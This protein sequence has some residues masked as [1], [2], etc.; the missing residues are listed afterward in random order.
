MRITS[1]RTGFSA[2]SA[3]SPAPRGPATPRTRPAAS[4]DTASAGRLKRP[5][6]GNR[7]P[8]SVTD[9]TRSAHR[10][11]PGAPAR[12]R[13]PR[14]RSANQP[15]LR[16]LL[17]APPTVPRSP[18]NVAC[19]DLEGVLVPE[20]WINVA[21]R[22]GI[23]ALRITTRDEPD[24]DVLMKR[25]LAIL[26]RARPAPARHPGRDRRHAAAARRRRV[27]RL[28]ARAR[29]GADP[30]RHLLRVRDAADAPA[31]LPDA[32]LPPPRRRRARAHRGL[33][34]RACPTR[35]AAPCEALRAS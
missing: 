26:E 30:L 18:V 1:T 3:G 25:R 21:E 33:P 8:C 28:A 11:A 10:R 34:I 14:P 15:P 4:R 16:D 31:R 20:I 24:Y 22:T 17:Q 23:E 12:Q 2:S 27:P 5:M 6:G 32:V 35:S 13:A 19:L 7:I 29:P 9:G